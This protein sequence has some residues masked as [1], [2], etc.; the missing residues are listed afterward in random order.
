MVVGSVCGGGGREKLE[1]GEEAIGP[2]A[3]GEVVRDAARAAADGV[4][5]FGGFP[6]EGR[7]GRGEPV[8]TETD[9]HLS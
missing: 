2:F 5:R 8:T 4:G 6:G 3:G 9:A 7:G 1:V